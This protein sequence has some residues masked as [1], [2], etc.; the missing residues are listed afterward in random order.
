MIPRVVIRLG[1]VFFAVTVLFV[2]SRESL[3]IPRYSARYGQKCLLCHQGPTG[4]GMRNL[5]ASQFLVPSEIAARPYENDSLA[6]P[7]PE[8]ARNVTIGADLRTLALYDNEHKQENDFLQMEGSVYLHFQLDRR[9]TAYFDRGMSGNYELYGTGFVLPAGGYFKVGRF[10]PA[11]GWRFADHTMFTRADLGYFDPPAHTD[12][13]VELGFFPGDASLNLAVMN[14][15]PGA[16]RD[17]D[18]RRMY[19]ARAEIR[20]RVG[21]MNIAAGAS[22]LAVDEEE[23][24][25][26][27]A[28]PFGYASWG[29]WTWV[30]EWDWKRREG[31]GGPTAFVTSH[32]FTRRIVQGVDLRAV[33]DFYDP[34]ID[35][36]TGARRRFGVGFDTLPYPFLGVLA[37]VNFL[38]YEDGLEVAGDDRVQTTAVVHFL[39]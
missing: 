11:Y 21:P 29:P 13:G 4:G 35:H 7:D 33:Y 23:A 20:R 30:G 5:Y 22:G 36:R 1:A 25:P 27:A 32:E 6:L 34:D 15:A 16:T 39:Y 28:G 10:T 3:S 38:G 17:T 37:M 26:W 31:D 14:G 8:I 19:V 2:L 18:G 12:V 24:R 9:F